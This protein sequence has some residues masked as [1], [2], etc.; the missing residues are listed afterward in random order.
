MVLEDLIQGLLIQAFRAAM[1]ACL[2][3]SFPK[4]MLSLVEGP[5][6]RPRMFSNTCAESSSACRD[7]ADGGSKVM[8]PCMEMAGEIWGRTDLQGCPLNPKP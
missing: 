1:R 4:I 3:M 8:R 5:V 6:Q 2:K 7:C